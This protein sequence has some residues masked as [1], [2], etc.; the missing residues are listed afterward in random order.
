M[1]KKTDNIVQVIKKNPTKQ[2]IIVGQGRSMGTPYIPYK[3]LYTEIVADKESAKV[4][5]KELNEEYKNIDALSINYF[6]L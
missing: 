6:S 4:R 2:K 3:I 5:V 1:A